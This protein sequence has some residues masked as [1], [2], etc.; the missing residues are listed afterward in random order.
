MLISNIYLK[1]SYNSISEKQIIENVG[2]TYIFSRKD[3]NSQ[4]VNE[5]LLNIINYEGNAYLNLYEMSLPP[6]VMDI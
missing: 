6:V 5:K 3:K 2:K 1:N 4:Q